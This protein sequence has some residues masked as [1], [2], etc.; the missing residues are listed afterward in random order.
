MYQWIDDGRVKRIIGGPSD[1][2]IDA[3]A[4][5]EALG[6]LLDQAKGIRR[7]GNITSDGPV[8]PAASNSGELPLGERKDAEGDAP[9]GERPSGSAPTSKEDTGYWAHKAKSEEYGALLRQA[10][11]LKEA[12]AL[13]STHGVRREGMETARSLRNAMMALPDRIAP[14]LDPANPARAHKLLTD[15]IRKA[16]REFSD[17]MAERAAAAGAEE[18]EASLV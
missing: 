13:T 12:G 4:S 8:T 17:R 10:Q 11:Y 14:V 9:G 2:K 15:E 6:A 7:D 1:G 16:L 5:H 3:D 18:C